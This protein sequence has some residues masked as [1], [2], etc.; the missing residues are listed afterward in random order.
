MRKKL[1]IYASAA[2]LLHVRNL[3]WCK[4]GRWKNDAREIDCLCCGEMN[5]MLV[6]S[7]KISE[8]EESISSCRF[9]G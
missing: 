5:A 7:A 6:A 8:R 4:C 9:F 3:D 2:D 1:N